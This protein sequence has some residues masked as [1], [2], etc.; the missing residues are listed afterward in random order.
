MPSILSLPPELLTE[1]SAHLPL[2]SQAALK[3]ACRATYHNTL[4]LQLGKCA[5]DPC[6]RLAIAAYLAFDPTRRRCPLCKHWYPASMFASALA[7]PPTTPERLRR[8][9]D[10]LLRR[11]SDALGGPGMLDGPPGACA[12]D[13][14]RV[15]RVVDCAHP[16]FMRVFARVAGGRKGS[17]R[18]VG[19]VEE[20]CYHCGTIRGWGRCECG[21]E[22]CGVRRV[23]T[24]TRLVRSQGDVE[25]FVFFKKGGEMWVREW[26]GRLCV[27]MKVENLD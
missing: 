3:L 22:T 7:P 17:Y 15:C 20:M 11:R 4:P 6:A 18:W 2:A 10:A 9:T 26:K 19:A 14:A 27:D 5:A 1:I 13:R 16:G 25:R 8:D 23:R 21:C 24:F 12:W